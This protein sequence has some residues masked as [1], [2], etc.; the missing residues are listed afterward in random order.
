MSKSYSVM[1]LPETVGSIIRV[2][3]RQGE[4]KYAVR[5]STGTHPWK[6]EGARDRWS[7]DTLLA[8]IDLGAGYK[9]VVG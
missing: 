5:L 8:R 3:T 6:V 9:I 4:K 2:K 1:D 7:T